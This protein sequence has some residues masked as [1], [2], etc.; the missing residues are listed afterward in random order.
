MKCSHQVGTFAISALSMLGILAAA[1][2]SASQPHLEDADYEPSRGLMAPLDR[3]LFPRVS[4]SETKGLPSTA[5]AISKYDS[6]LLS[7]AQMNSNVAAAQKINPDLLIFRKFNPGGYLGFMSSNACTDAFGIAFGSTAATTEN[8]GFFAGHWAYY[9]GTMLSKAIAATATKV[10]VAD[11]SRVT[12]GRYVVIYDAP[13]GSFKNAEHALVASVSGNVVTFAKRGYKSVARSHPAGAIV[14]EHPVAGGANGDETAEHWMYNMSSVGPADAKGRRLGEITADWLAANLSTASNGGVVPVRVDGLVFDTDAWSQS[15]RTRL[16]IDNDLVA[17]GGWSRT[18]DTNYWGEGMEQFYQ[19]VRDRLP[20][21]VVAGGNPNL[22]GYDT[23][24]GTQMEGFPVSGTYHS[25]NPQYERLDEL[26]ANYILHLREGPQQLASYTE[27]LSKTPTKLYPRGATPTP[28]SNAPFRFAFAATLLDDGYY[29]QE[30]LSVSQDP[31]W[32]EFAVDVTPGSPTY[33]Q[34]IASNPKDE[35]LTRVHRGWLGLPLGARERVFDDAAFDV[36]RSLFSAGHLD[37]GASLTG[38]KSSNVALSFDASQAMAGTGSLR[39]SNHQ[40]YAALPYQASVRTP[41]VA[42]RAGV[43]YTL[44]FSAKAAE[45]RNIAI[46]AGGSTQSFDIPEYWVRRVMTFTASTTGTSNISFNVGRED[47][48]LWLDDV[49]L[50]E[51]N[52]N[53]FTREFQNGLVVVNATSKS[54]TV[55]LGTPY[56]RIKGTQDPVNDGSKVTS[57]TIGPNDAAILVALPTVPRTV[58]VTD[59]S[60]VESGGS[61]RFAVSL[62]GPNSVPVTVRYATTNG[63]AL[64]GSDYTAISG[65]LSFAPGSTLQTVTVPVLDD[66]LHEGTE[67]FAL[68]L[69]NAVGATLAKATATGT[70]TDNDNDNAPIAC[71]TLRSCN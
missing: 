50:F 55:D 11:A 26:F 41:S 22:R 3:H 33:G 48:P 67:G 29:A 1:S 8:C 31:W 16:D 12:A 52:A 30:P 45:V 51:G 24:S 34:A 10:T 71:R 36:S 7:A 65:S 47:I 63:S 2:A 28:T 17:D 6:L 21:K 58:S 40:S 13:T 59:V 18:D 44:V 43:D 9:A 49:Y 35:T 69:S 70:I 46:G 42:L 27:N 54:R 62:S 19:Q 56:L 38:W 39:V 32:D 23:L 60:V 5:E 61:A 4:L 15:W 37:N 68:V 14:A 53:I 64:A 25:A 57:V 20:D 66:V